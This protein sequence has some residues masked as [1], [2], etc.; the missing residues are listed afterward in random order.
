MSL[1]Q[2][3]SVVLTAGSYSFD[4]DSGPSGTLT[5]TI[6]DAT[7]VT[8]TYT[9]FVNGNEGETIEVTNEIHMTGSRDD[10]STTTDEVILEES[11]G[12]IVGKNGELTLQ[13]IGRY[14]VGG[15][16]PNLA[17]ATFKL[18]KLNLD[19]PDAEPVELQEA[20]TA[21]SD[22]VL[23][24]NRDENQ[25]LQSDTLYY[26]VETD[27]PEGYL[28]N[29]NPVYFMLDPSE[30]AI[31]KLQKNF[32]KIAAQVRN[33]AD[34]GT[35]QVADER[36]PLP[37][38]KEFTAKK[39]VNGQDA[40]G[41]EFTFKLEFTGYTPKQGGYTPEVA[42]DNGLLTSTENVPS[43][44]DQTERNDGAKITFEKVKFE[45]EGT[46]TF[47]VTE[48][49]GDTS[50]YIFDSTEYT[51]EVVVARSVGSGN[52]E[53]TSTKYKKG[54]SEVDSI[55]F[56]NTEL[57][58]FTL[59]KTTTVPVSEDTEFEFTITAKKD[60]ANVSFESV[61]WTPNS[62]NVTVE[63]SSDN[64]TLTVKLKVLNQSAQSD[65]VTFNGIPVG[66]QVTI[67]EAYKEKWA[68]SSPTSGST[69]LSIN[70][71][72][73]NAAVFTNKPDVTSHTVVKV[74][75]DENNKNGN[76]PTSIIVQLK[77]NGQ[78]YRDPETLTGPNWTYTWD[79]LPKT[80]ANGKEYVYTVSESE[81]AHYDLD[82]AVTEG[83]TIT[84]KPK[85]E[86]VSHTINKVWEDGNNADG[87]RP[88]SITVQLYNGSVAYGDPVTVEPL[89][90]GTW[91][92][93]W[94]NLP[95]Y[96]NGQEASYRAVEVTVPT[97]YEKAETTKDDITTITNSHTFEE[98]SRVVEKKWEGQY[99]E[100]D[101]NRAP[102]EVEL[103]AKA[104]I[105]GVKQDI[106]E[107]S[108][109]TLNSD[110]NWRYEWKNLP[111]Y[112]QGQEIEYS[113][114]EKTDLSGKGYTVSYSSENGIFASGDTSTITIT[115][116]YI[117]K[118]T[119][120]TVEKVWDDADN[121]DGKR[122]ATIKV[123][124]TGTVGT[125]QVYQDSQI[126]SGSQTVA[127]GLTYTWDNL[128]VYKNGQE[129]VYTITETL[130]DDSEIPGYTASQ[131]T[132]N[133]VEDDIVVGKKIILTNSM[134]TEEVDIT[135]TK[136]WDDNNDQD[137]I[138]PESVRLTLYK[139]V[140]TDITELTT[141]VVNAGNSWQATWSN[142][143]K[144][145]NGTEI[146]YYVDEKMV[147]TGYEKSYVDVNGNPLQE[148]E[149]GLIIRNSHIPE[150]TD[151]TV[152]KVWDDNNNQDGIRPTDKITVTLTA[153]IDSTNDVTSKIPA[154]QNG[155]NIQDITPDVANTTGAWT[156]AKWE[157]LP[158]YWE[159]KKITYSITEEV[160][161]GYQTSITTPNNE[162]SFVVTNTHKPGE[163]SIT[164]KKIWDDDSNRDNVRHASV[165]FQLYKTVNGTTSKVE[166]GQK[167]LTAAENG[168][169]GN[170]WTV[171]WNNLPE[172]E[173]GYAIAYTV[174]E[175]DPETGEPLTNEELAPYTSENN[176][177]AG[178]GYEITNKYIPESTSVSVTKIWD[179]SN[180]IDNRRPS[181]ITMTLSA[182]IV[183]D[184]EASSV[185]VL[186]YNQ[187]TNTYETSSVGSITVTQGEEV[188]TGKSTVVILKPNADGE[189]P[190]YE[191]TNLAKKYRDSDGN[192]YD[193]VYSVEESPVE[194]YET[195]ITNDGNAFTVTNTYKIA[196]TELAVI[197]T[198]AD[199]SDRDGIR[200]TEL[201]VQL[202][203]DGNTYYT[204]YEKN[205]TDG[206][207]DGTWNTK[208][209][210]IPVLTLSADDDW[211]GSWKDLPVYNS[212]HERIVY[213]I[214]ELDEITGYEQ[215]EISS[216]IVNGITTFMLTNTHE[217]EEIS[218]Q[219]IKFWMDENA[220][221]VERP[222]TATF[223]LTK[224]EWTE[225]T[226]G[227]YVYGEP[228]EVD[229]QTLTVPAKGE[230][231]ILSFSWSGLTKMCNGEPI[232][233][234]IIEA[235][236][237]DGY[238][239]YSDNKE[240]YTA[241]YNVTTKVEVSKT[242][243]SGEKEIPGAKLQI[244]D[245]N[246]TV[247]D[248][249]I[250]EAEKS[251]VVTG[252][253]AG[254]TYTLHEVSA[255]DGYLTADDI[256]FT[257]KSD[258]TTTQV[259][260][261]D[262]PTEI[263]ISKKDSSGTN[264]LR[265]AV[266]E[267][268]EAAG[269][270]V[271]R[272]TSDGSSHLI[273]GKLNPGITYTLVEVT[274]PDGYA[275]AENVDFI[276]NNE[277]QVLVITENGNEPA[278]NN[279]IVVEDELRKIRFAK[280][281]AENNF[282]SGAELEVHY[283]TTDGSIGSLVVTADGTAMKWTSR[284]A[285]EEFA[286]IRKGEYYL[287][288]V[289]APEGYLQ[290]DALEFSV[291]GETA[292]DAE[293][294]L[295]SLENK[296]TEIQIE[297]SFWR[298]AG[299][300][301]NYN[302]A[303]VFTILD[304]SG[305]VVTTV[306]GDRLENIEVTVNEA[307]TIKG[308]PA[309]NYILREVS[310]PAGYTR[311]EDMPFT[312]SSDTILSE[313]IQVKD[314]PVNVV[315]TKM[316]IT[317]EEGELLA[318]AEFAVI[319][320]DT[321]DA[322][323]TKDAES[324]RAMAA[325]N[326][327][328]ETLLFITEA[329]S[330][331]TLE[332]VEPGE[333]YLVEIT[334]PTGY[335]KLEEPI[336]FTVEKNLAV[337]EADIALDT[338]YNEPTEISF[339]K[340]DEQT[341]ELLSGAG[342]EIRLASEEEGSLVVSDEKAAS[343]YEDVETSW[344]SGNSAY[345]VTGLPVGTYALVETEVPDGYVKADPI[346]FEINEDG[347]GTIYYESGTVT[348][349]CIEMLDDTT[350]IE[351]SKVAITGGAE[352]PGATLQI[353][354]K[355]VDADGKETENIIEE[356]VSTE[357]THMIEGK[358]V[359]GKEYILREITAP[360]GYNVA[361][362]ITFKVDETG[363][364]QK[365]KM[366]DESTKVSFSKKA[367][368]GGAELPGATLQVLKTVTLEDG[369]TATVVVEQW[370]SGNEEHLIEAKLN[371]GETYILREII[372][373]TGYTVANDVT[374]TVEAGGT[375]QQVEMIDEVIEVEISKIDITNDEELPGA[376]LQILNK[377]TGEIATTI[378][379]DETDETTK[380]ER[381]EWIS[382]EE[383]RVIR[384]LP[385][386]EY[387]LHEEIAPEGYTIAKDIEFT[388]SD[389]LELNGSVVQ[390]KNAPTEVNVSKVEITNSQELEGAF[391]QILNK[392]T[393]EVAVT[394]YGETLSWVSNGNPKNIKGLPAGEYILR[395]TAA[396]D[397]YTIAK[398]IE[399][400]ITDELKVAETI[401]MEDAPTEV[402]ISK[403]DI[404]TGEELPGATLQIR[405]E[406]GNEVVTTI[407]GERLEWVSGREPKVIRGLPAGNYILREISAPDGYTITTEDVEFTITNELKPAETVVMVNAPS[408]VTISK[409]DIRNIDEEL[410][411]ATLQILDQ[412]G[413]VVRTVYNERLE[414]ITTGEAKEILGLRDG[415][416][417]LREIS[418]P[419]GFTVAED[420]TFT[421]EH[422][423]VVD[424]SAD[425]VR[426]T[427]RASVVN[428]S[429]TDITNSQELPGATLQIL[430]A[431]GTSVV[432]TIY[433]ERLEWVSQE[434]PKVIEG[435]PAGDYILR[436]ITAPDGYTVA[437]DVRFTIQANLSVAQ[438]AETI[439]MENA[440]T[441]INVSKLDITNSQEIEGAFLQILNAAT[442]E[443]AVTIYGET[444]SWVSN[445]IPKNIKGL[446]AGEY[447]LRETAAPNGYAIANEIAFTITD[448]L[449]T[450]E[451]VTMEDAPTEVVISKT[452]ITTGEELPG[453]TLQVLNEQGTEIVTTI[454]G[455][456]LEWVSGEEPKVI[457]GLPEGNYILR[458]ITAPNGYTIAEDV[459]FTITDDGTVETRVTMEN[460]PTE[461]NISKVD[462]TTADQ[463]LPGATLQVLDEFGNEVITTIYGERLEWVSGDT[464]K[465]ITGLPAGTYIL[466]EI[467]AP[468]GYTV[469]E[470]VRFT[471]T[472]ELKAAETVVMENKAT[473]VIVSKTD[474]TTGE[475]LPGAELQILDKDGQ[476]IITTIYGEELSWISGQEPKVITGLPAGD[477]ILREITAP[478]GYTV[479][480]D[481]PF[482]I[483][484]DLTVEN[485]V[486]MRDAPTETVI[487]KVS[488]VD[489]NRELEGA[490]LQ[491]L[492]A[493]GDVAETIYGERLEWIS[494]TEPKEILG[495]PAGTYILREVQAPDGYAIAEDIEFT[496]SSDGTVT[497]VVMKDE[498]TQV[499]I[500][501]IDASTG[502]TLIGARLA[503]KDAEGNTIDD[504]Y[505][506]SMPKTFTGELKAGETYTLTELS[507]PYG[508]NLAEDIPFVVNTDGEMQT[509]TM[510][511]EV[512][513]G[514]GSV[515]VQK[516][517]KQD[518][519]YIAVDYTF[520]VALFSDEALTNR[521]T[522][523]KPI[524]VS[525]SYTASTLFSG[526]EYGT[527][528]VAETDID[529]NPISTSRV[530]ESNEII[531]GEVT[532]TPGAATAKSTI[533]NHVKNFEPDYY[534]DG[535]LTVNKSVLINGTPGN[536]N[537][538]FY[539]ALFTDAALTMMADA[540]VQSLTLDGE[541]NGTVVFEQLPLG[542]YYLAETDE[543]GIPVDGLTFKYDVTIESSY[544]Q[545]TQ[546]NQTAVRTVVN[547]M[548]EEEEPTES[549]EPDTTP[550]TTPSTSTKPSGGSKPSSNTGTTIGTKPTKTGDNTEIMWYILG[551]S[552]S[553][554]VLAVIYEM[555]RRKTRHNEQD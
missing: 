156:T 513:D 479:A 119:K 539:F 412:N 507:A 494:G 23:V 549:E 257:V 294:Q 235:E 357:E 41:K 534:M 227:D 157:N 360:D 464:P 277:G 67:T 348:G 137:G 147:P 171:S 363:A 31:S 265:G 45:Y 48:E 55:S 453:A 297:K 190:S 321:Y 416:Y 174:K 252:L 209:V 511:D 68:V 241:I 42:K 187:E 95:K 218:K 176:G 410:P 249:W 134:T 205:L 415:T 231:N 229:R 98:V 151:I 139:K 368:T 426:M 331:I 380:D 536:V 71:S 159:G 414:W 195:D 429:K 512:A 258:G 345:T 537:D 408:E 169:S 535:E 428:I 516:L 486:E 143:P 531:D 58:S 385:A 386:G 362:D 247:I 125:E 488:A 167:T 332:G 470:D 367:I 542:T 454:Y 96:I 517:V 524:E 110:N 138:R 528:Y 94:E 302:A 44:S 242:D 492:N 140:N 483:T 70:S 346:F 533:V 292:E 548:E 12:T 500:I 317:G 341:G 540:G 47:K 442:G 35:V 60:S 490:S 282:V 436:E 522:S 199:D 104:I 366:I 173:N 392:Q 201:E 285:A 451:T 122:P 400:T 36:V 115:N 391:L 365:I 423:H 6:P 5:I 376:T 240:T 395:E 211:M 207:W 154:L 553:G 352:L 270:V 204:V 77:Q 236:V 52:L 21:G 118:L 72:G 135:A 121:Q 208:N 24:F 468:A 356:W 180:N 318:G 245:E 13:K 472:D 216:S 65:V 26:W 456:R 448:E 230:G 18:Y 132:E 440:P 222:E 145:E 264:H 274:A 495:L 186:F 347:T 168:L 310:A 150:T 106:A 202:L 505:T 523:V 325:E 40:T 361:S 316:D 126:L 340:K 342:L 102:V 475:E 178:N 335:V 112:Y 103:H 425:T 337:T 80:D 196:T 25:L 57:T 521:V 142:L 62:S 131:R 182:S 343:V 130:A 161:D 152:T 158:K 234:E 551:L 538:T 267:I 480:E 76:R 217:T 353:I 181:Q 384:G 163:T 552:A 422:G 111:K 390:M 301:E 364:V 99:E 514:Q 320:K 278:D 336:A 124:L 188:P 373:P 515:I 113:V 405:N 172:K 404:T 92:C 461:V 127:N 298:E 477:Y 88:T 399:F 27:A 29:R 2:Y 387:I 520:Y 183:K 165:T 83:T 326:V 397:G 191:W 253:T 4:P 214:Q 107:V 299:E 446:P 162:Y 221:E 61:T 78:N 355:V 403:T 527:Y 146:I 304:M 406:L 238:Q 206:V 407:Y 394:I 237:P 293:I 220:P 308:I 312:V 280:V 469:A 175:V 449:K 545:L 300:V 550:N 51:I 63:K 323:E 402:I 388:I 260:L 116:T 109:V 383:P 69:V 85:T 1:R 271:E 413:D 22:G 311:A 519:R 288:E 473:E 105:N 497:N 327:F 185:P 73:N 101:N 129:I 484:D 466:R 141:K 56:D 441:E 501:K 38:E 266:F 349:N 248:E 378:F 433:G 28:I 275:L 419:A 554:I 465:V 431:E 226:D 544:I 319:A 296:L 382:G 3:T 32:P 509:I 166:G 120:R 503:L 452:D 369:S 255:P 198:W 396:P 37:V 81:V 244:L 246:K 84:N 314:Y 8:L 177:N 155:K 489:G 530:I 170:E 338:V 287:V 432:T 46:Y 97:G 100:D 438:P 309:G 136:Q 351:I 437:E 228:V 279:E 443:V 153:V 263:R 496:V 498:Q 273:E 546:E 114:V 463:E 289:S 123:T 262:E 424:T 203:A 459:T 219:L 197:K 418:A 324:L 445:G 491:V 328:G 54:S 7:P 30:E 541:S 502:D 510:E 439:V 19:D 215:S 389:K 89:A 417:T 281:D 462:I 133:I 529:G 11:A 420:V 330:T 379:Y 532:L 79:D 243:L 430:D 193:I 322:A 525:G 305:N 268:R 398:D 460:K 421:V 487:S 506:T 269:N 39:T 14:A 212:N 381:L 427:N 375:V 467:T 290:T 179:D 283:K 358:L 74:W 276:I 53:V 194:D 499:Q 485:R 350:K 543:D 435:L 291:T 372:A 284:T 370:E 87:L 82:S 447:I 144:Y 233:Y 75:D 457:Q 455:E 160:V 148:G 213:T 504:W 9:V 223:I 33:Y 239:V 250:S 224:S 481:V 444:L 401:T 259:T 377:E 474:I 64:R 434:T 49:V 10:S 411:G 333:Y 225:Q 303:A 90:N 295:I 329:A 272:W 210:T 66:A 20:T 50:K 393:G 16:I 251:H 547:S 450:A 108:I 555:R 261:R 508:Y 339:V 409:T 43:Y 371:V 91:T 315:I 17:G 493:D 93:T 286:G 307:V 478:D 254:A 232:I 313:P 526:L 184:G 471:I 164:A 34:G 192:V 256:T 458:E 334:A 86:T 518:D 482:T 306:K 15:T 374:F 354:E 117:R 128:L 189:W 149:V 59:Q 476:E 359:V 200:P 344:E